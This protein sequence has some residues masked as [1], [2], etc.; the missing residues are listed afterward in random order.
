V[1]RFEARPRTVDLFEQGNQVA[2]HLDSAE[3]VGFAEVEIR[4]PKPAQE[5]PAALDDDGGHRRT[6]L[7]GELEAVPQD[8]VNACSRHGLL[9]TLEHPPIDKSG[10]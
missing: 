9:D 4:V 2:A 6:R 10:G 5:N 1:P 7:R 8:E 3:H